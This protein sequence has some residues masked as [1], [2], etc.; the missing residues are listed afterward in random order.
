MSERFIIQQKKDNEWI[1]IQS[2]PFYIKSFAELAMKN[3]MEDQK[4]MNK[5][6]PELRLKKFNA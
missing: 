5:I 4:S 1:D 3:L 6:K 2:D